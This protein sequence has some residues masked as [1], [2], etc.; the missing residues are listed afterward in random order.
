VAIGTVVALA[1]NLSA[2]LA[3]TRTRSATEA[4]RLAGE[5]EAVLAGRSG[6]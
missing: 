2:A 3:S 5:R 1:P 6:D 4:A